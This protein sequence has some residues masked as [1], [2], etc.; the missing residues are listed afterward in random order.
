MRGVN[1]VILLGNLGTAPELRFTANETPIATFSLAT[2]ENYKDQGG[3]WKTKTEW[4]RVVVFGKIAQSCAE[5][6]KKGSQ[7]YVEGRIQTRQWEDRDGVKRY[8]TEIVARDIQFLGG[9]GIEGGGQDDVPP[10]NSSAGMPTDGNFEND[11][12]LPF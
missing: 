9:R 11:D 5:Y 4:H 3:E 7:A 12:D 1:K 10:A 8:T 6:L 2:N